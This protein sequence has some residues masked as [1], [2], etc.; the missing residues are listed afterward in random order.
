MSSVSTAAAP[1]RKRGWSRKPTGSVSRSVE[2][3]TTSIPSCS[4]RRSSARAI[5]SARSPRLAPMPMYARIVAILARLRLAVVIALAVMGPASAAGAPPSHAFDELAPR[6]LGP[7]AR[8]V[9]ALSGHPFSLVE[10]TG[11]RKAEV[12]LAL[13]GG[14]PVSRRFGI[15]R[16]R[17]P[18]AQRIVPALR[19]AGLVRAAEP[20]RP[21]R[22]LSHVTSGDPL[23]PNEWWIQMI[24]A[25]RAE[26]PGPGK[27]VTVIDS[28]VDLAHPSSP[29]GPA[30]SR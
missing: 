9:Q 15:W 8:A 1:F 28:G 25:D 24:G 22:A 18:A 13:A 29:A 7:P 17:T 26:P 10:V 11:G 30:R 4:P 3:A 20:D 23:V 16:L 14:K 6:A 5:V 2:T 19:A 12:A 27:P 21:V